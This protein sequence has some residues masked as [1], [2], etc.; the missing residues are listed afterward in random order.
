MLEGLQDE[1]RLPAAFALAFVVTFALTPV[2]RRLATATQFYDH[3]VGYKAHGCPTPYLGG[4]AVLAGVLVSSV[5][6]ADAFSEYLALLVC[7]VGLAAVGTLDDR[8][9]LM[10]APRLA[11][12][13]AAAVVLW[14]AGFGWDLFP[15]DGAD[16]GLTVLWVVSLINAFN[17][18][19]NLDGAAG[20]VGAVCAVGTAVLAA[21]QG[22]AL[23]AAFTLA[24]AGACAGFLPH[25]LARPSRIFLGD[26][27]ST[28][29]GFF[30]AA[31][32]IS[33]PE[34]ALDW[35][36]LFA[37]APLVGIP[38]FDTTL[39]VVSRRRRGARIL[40]GARDHLTHRLV[41][42]LRSPRRVALALGGAQAG[43]SL[44]A[45]ALHSLGQ[46]AALLGVLLVVTVGAL[47]LLALESSGRVLK[48][49][50]RMS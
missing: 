46:T 45:I 24:L 23:L 1:V 38:I 30:L 48:L 44:I 43:L 15:G 4:A 5:L 41:M 37:S 36:T 22:D 18:M 7:G 12:Q 27:G 40:A 50:E 3:P 21:I 19:D 9:G 28:P 29:I 39:V 11:A 14:T 8:I 17:L 6:F 33:I 35:V 34:G 2:M 10:V 31:A 20:T 49:S 47:V 32:I 16:F 42:V 13:I 25:N 26:G